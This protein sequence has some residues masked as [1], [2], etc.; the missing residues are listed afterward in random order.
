MEKGEF[1]T[2]VEKSKPF[3]FGKQKLI[4]KR[5]KL[6]YEKLRNYLNGLAPDKETRITIANQIK[7]ILIDS[8]KD[9]DKII[10]K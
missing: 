9:I 1:I 6:S 2:F 4:A 5:C 7:L 8:K 3:I 10:K